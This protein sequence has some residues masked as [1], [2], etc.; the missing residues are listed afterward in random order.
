M[1][2]DNSHPSSSIW[3]W[4]LAS[5]RVNDEGSG[6]GRG[7]RERECKR[8]ATASFTAWLPSLGIEYHPSLLP[9]SIDHTDQALI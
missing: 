6:K 1:G 4:Q 5:L 7:E 3:P 9:Y 2:L 8:E